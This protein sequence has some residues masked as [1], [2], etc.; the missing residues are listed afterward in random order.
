MRILEIS[1]LGYPGFMWAFFMNIIFMVLVSLMFKSKDNK[2]VE[3][4]FFSEAR[5]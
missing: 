2:E 3:E 4:K 5:R 1:P